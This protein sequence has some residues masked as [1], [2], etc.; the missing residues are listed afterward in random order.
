MEK[1]NGSQK[2]N[3]FDG[4]RIPVSP[5]PPTRQCICHLQRPLSMIVAL[6]MGAFLEPM[7]FASLSSLDRAILTGEE[8]F[9][10]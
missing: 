7:I 6:Q 1:R 9:W 2:S 4:L 3:F 10:L 5:Q 8:A